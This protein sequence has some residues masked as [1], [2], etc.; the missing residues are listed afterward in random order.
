MTPAIPVVIDTDI[1]SDPDDALALVLAL[2]SPEIDVRAVTI[3]SG[4]VSLRARMAARLLGMAGRPDIPVFMGQGE[5]ID[6]DH[7]VVMDGREGLGLLNLPYGGPEAIIHDKPAVDW[8]LAESRRDPFH[9]V[10]IGPQTNVALA[11]AQDPGFRE[12]LL[13]VTAMGGLLDVQTMPEAWRRDIAERGM[14]AWPDYNTTS[15]PAAALVVSH[16][17]SPMTWVPLDVT[18]RAPLRQDSRDR[19]PRDHPLGLA[20]V[21]MID[22]WHASWFPTALPPPHDPSPVPADAV[23]ILH[24]PLAI[25]ALFPGDWLCLRPT[26]LDAWMED[27]IF[28]LGEDDSGV[29]GQ[30]AFDINGGKLEAF[31][32]ARIL[33]QL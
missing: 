24:D 4:D 12:R 29:P 7:Q 2:A 23:A 16:A 9:L 30:V 8:L 18:M 25:A 10:T 21:W 32:M 5:S 33:R 3:V 1:G 31:F 14:A 13:G 26:R 11:L 20:L 6:P 22:A 27:G 19:L 15:D 28:R 17:A